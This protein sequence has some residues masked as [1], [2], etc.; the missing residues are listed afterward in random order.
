MT[1]SSRKSHGIALSLLVA[2]LVAA[3][4][5]AAQPPCVGDCQGSGTV[6]INELIICVG[7]SLGDR[8]VLDCNSCD[9]NANGVV[10]IN[11]LIQAVNA[12]LNGCPNVSTP[13]PPQATDT[14]GGPTS[15]AT[16][17]PTATVPAPTSTP[18]SDIEN[19]TGATAAIANAVASIPN[20]LGAVL[21]GVSAT[22]SAQ[23][24]LSGIPGGGAGNVDACELGGTV[25]EVDNLPTLN[26]VLDDCR[27]S[28]PGGS[29]LF[30]GTLIVTITDFIPPL[31]GTASF[32]ADITFFDDQGQVLTTTSAALASP[33][34]LAVAGA[35]GDPCAIDVPVL[36]EVRITRIDL[37]SLTGTLETQVTDQGTSDVTWN[38]TN[39]SIAV[40]A[41]SEDCVP[42]DFDV[43]VN[44][45]AT[46]EYS[47][48]SAPAAPS[49]GFFA[50]VFD[51]TFDDFVVSAD[52]DGNASEIEISGDLTSSCLGETVTLSTPQ[53]LS[54]LLGQFCPSGG[55][56]RVQD[57]GDIVY[58]PA[59]VEVNGMSYTSCVDPALLQCS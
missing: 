12:A 36:N 22:Q 10:A 25:T 19:V 24:T 55:T 15:T 16:A 34:G 37:T 7:I 13:T 17:T 57:I 5:A 20:V 28:R 23:L 2:A 6:Q 49:G 43:T 48:P 40:A 47:G 58:S 11:E 59:G 31:G 29:A 9:S 21:A 44:G 41:L 52:G 51:V 30:D 54:F 39:V 27:V 14:P 45:D 56:L 33:L 1:N 42:V 53:S 8:P 32:N 3:A 4:P 38:N 35:P 46:M 26:L 50:V 18:A